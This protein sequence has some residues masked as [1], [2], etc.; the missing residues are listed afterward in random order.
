M[1]VRSLG[2]RA[3]GTRSAVIVAMLLVLFAIGTSAVR[4]QTLTPPPPADAECQTSPVGT[5]CRWT[6]TFGTPFPVP[7]RVTC[8]GFAVLVDLSGERRIT[9][10]YDASGTLERRIRHATFS[11][12]LSNS[13]TGA[14]V[15][16][17]GHFTAVD[18]LGAGTSA[19]TGRLSRTVLPGEGVVWRNIGR[20]VLSSA[21]GA[22]L[23]EAGEHGTWAVL[24]DPSAAEE[25]CTALG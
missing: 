23:F 16:H 12:T 13:V 3:T 22:V 20:V 6:E 4:A 17:Q 7:Y 25:L 5:I 15:P 14:T 1:S 8:D 10:F 9:A 18:D 2:L 21:N 11:G 24:T 19:I